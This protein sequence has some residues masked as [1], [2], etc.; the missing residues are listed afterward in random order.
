[1]NKKRITIYKT[2]EEP[3]KDQLEK[4]LRETPEERYR[5]FFTMQARLWALKGRPK[6]AKRITVSKPSW[7]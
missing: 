3:H 1:M 7:I 5:G 6:L 4:G 2:L